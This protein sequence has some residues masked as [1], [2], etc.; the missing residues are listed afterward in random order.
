MYYSTCRGLESSPEHVTGTSVNVSAEA[1]QNLGTTFDSNFIMAFHVK[2]VV[3]KARF[4]LKN[5]GKVGKLL[6][7]DAKKTVMQNLVISRIDYCNAL[8]SGIQQ[9]TMAK[10]QRLQNHSART[11]TKIESTF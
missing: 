6:T 5:I 9:D 4:H 2:S 8:L 10:R 3:E 7:E 1:G 11:V